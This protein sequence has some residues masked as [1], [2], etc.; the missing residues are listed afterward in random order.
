MDELK[1]IL[2]LTAGVGEMLIGCGA[3]ISR[4]EDTMNRIALHY[5]ITRR[6]I[7]IIAN[8]VFVNL[9]KGDQAKNVSIQ[10]IPQ[11]SVDL[12]KLCDINSLS[13]DIEQKNLDI[14]EALR[15]YDEIKYRKRINRTGHILASG[16]GAGAFCYLFGGDPADCAGALLMGLILW[17]FFIAVECLKLS[18]VLLHI[19]GA[20]IVTS[21]CILMMRAGLIH[22]L[23]QAIMG[24]II[25]MIP[26]V[27]FTNG[28]RDIADGDYISGGIRLLDAVLLFIC[29]AAGVCIALKIFHA[30][31]G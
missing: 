14:D 20:F 26:G 25:P 21:G 2:R 5:G 29:I 12:D 19:I 30:G 16:V 24:A 8:G 11:V 3:E 7:F 4:V 9:E 23:N 22:H 27:A 15:R 10:H 13:R 17:A 6:Q 18:K 28:I 1:K 31:L